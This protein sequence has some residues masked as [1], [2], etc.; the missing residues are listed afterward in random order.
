MHITVVLLDKELEFIN[1]ENPSCVKPPLLDID[2]M[3]LFH[4]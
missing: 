2:W 3:Q 4:P 1:S